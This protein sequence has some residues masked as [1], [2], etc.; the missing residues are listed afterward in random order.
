M[1]QAKLWSKENKTFMI[2][3][4]PFDMPAPKPKRP[5]VLLFDIGGVCVRCNWFQIDSATVQPL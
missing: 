3:G 1:A 4:E 2:F 5:Q